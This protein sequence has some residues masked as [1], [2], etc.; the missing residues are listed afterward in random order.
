MPFSWKV[1]MLEIEN[2]GMYPTWIHDAISQ[3]NISVQMD[4]ENKN[5]LYISNI[6]RF[7]YD[8]DMILMDEE[9]KLSINNK[10]IEVEKIIDN[11]DGSADI[12]FSLSHEMLVHFAK[13]G[14]L[15]T[16]TDEAN[17]IKKDTT[18]VE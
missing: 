4:L 7:A 2:S 12:T 9:G 16:I 10:D 6:E 3:G 11:P 14:L 13:I 15:K 5:C 8:G 18:Y 17:F 1:D